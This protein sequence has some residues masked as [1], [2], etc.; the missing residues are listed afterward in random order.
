MQQMFTHSDALRSDGSCS[1]R[2]A[3]S[4]RN[5]LSCIL[6]SFHTMCYLTTRY[7]LMP[8]GKAEAAAG[9]AAARWGRWLGAFL[10]Y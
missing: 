2:R 9:R 5:Q 1:H 4:A 3:L 10:A 6:T 7:P 8:L